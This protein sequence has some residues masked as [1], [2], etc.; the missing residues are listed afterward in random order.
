MQW[1]ISV[2]SF[3][4]MARLAEPLMP[5]GGCFLTVS[6]YGAEK[7]SITLRGLAEPLATRGASLF[8]GF[9]RL[10]ALRLVGRCS[11]MT[12]RCQRSSYASA[13]KLCQGKGTRT[14]DPTTSASGWSEMASQSNDARSCA[15]WSKLESEAGHRVQRLLPAAQPKRLRGFAGGQLV[16]FQ[17]ITSHPLGGE[18]AFETIADR[19]GLRTQEASSPPVRHA[20]LDARHGSCWVL[21]P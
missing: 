10:P 19:R 15:C 16:D 7:V 6:C 8:H 14:K 11:H 20:R 1:R 5:G 13:F 3:I 9:V 4:R 12:A 21:R 18:A 2:Y 17:V